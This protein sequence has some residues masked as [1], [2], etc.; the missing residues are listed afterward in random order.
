METKAVKLVNE[1]EYLHPTELKDGDF[2]K[3]WN[4]LGRFIYIFKKC[5]NNI[6]YRHASFDLNCNEVNVDSSIKWGKFTKSTKITYATEEEKNLL[7]AALLKEGYIWINSTKELEAIQIST[8]LNFSDVSLDFIEENTN[9]E[10]LNLFPTKKHYQL[11][12]NY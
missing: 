1:N 8:F 2:I 3:I 12:F 9:K 4:N 5:E 7:N 11:N 10:E 6:I